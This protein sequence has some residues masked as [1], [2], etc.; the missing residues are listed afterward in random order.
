MPVSNFV[1]EKENTQRILTNM[2]C[3]QGPVCENFAIQKGSWVLVT[4]VNGYVASHVANQLLQ[5]G[6]NVR[7][8]VR[9]QSKNKWIKELFEAKYENCKFE[10]MQVEDAACSG[11]FNKAIQGRV[12]Y[13]LQFAYLPSVNLSA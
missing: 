1:D 8:T 6:Y 13:E 9:D 4:G 11:A 2:E 10:L 3:I 12:H 5:F 7:G